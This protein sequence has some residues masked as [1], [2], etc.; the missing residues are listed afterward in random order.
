MRVSGRTLKTLIVGIVAALAVVACGGDDNDELTLNFTG[1][2]PLANGFHYE[3]WAIIDGSPAPTGKFNVDGNG[4]LVDLSGAVGY[5]SRE[6]SVNRLGHGATVGMVGELL[7]AAPVAVRA[8]PRP[9]PWCEC[10]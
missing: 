6:G 10:S 5:R 9:R 2:D 3:G 7:Q 8:G 1:L 4:R